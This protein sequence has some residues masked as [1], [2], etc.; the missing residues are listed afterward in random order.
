MFFL[1]L[2]VLLTMFATR[3]EWKEVLETLADLYLSGRVP[4]QPDLAIAAL[5]KAARLGSDRAHLRLGDLYSAGGLL[6]VDYP[7]ALDHYRQAAGKGNV[8]AKVR[9]AE[10]KEGGRG[11]TRD[12]VGAI[13]DLKVLADRG[14]DAAALSLG[15]IYADGQ[16][17]PADPA[18][19]LHYYQQAVSNGSVA[20]L[21]RLGDFYCDNATADYALALDYY[22]QAADD[23]NATAKVRLAEM[24]AKGQGM[25][26]DVA[27]A[28][29]ELEVL[30]AADQA[31]ASLALGDIY[32]EGRVVPA[33]AALALHYYRQANAQGSLRRPRLTP[34]LGTGVAGLTLSGGF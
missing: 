1:A 16:I 19:A 17:V 30:A 21:L 32:G 26:R 11:V 23:G 10:M 33:D 29:A 20:G 31:G 9:L 6:A 5:R 4:A 15:D 2:I 24:K 22:R 3:I 8:E 27:S 34:M 28:L 14:E 18:L 12:P 25:A 13:A 7:R